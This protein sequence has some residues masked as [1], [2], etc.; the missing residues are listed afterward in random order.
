VT[1]PRI[2]LAAV[3]VALVCLVG[4]AAAEVSQQGS[5]IT[6]FDGKLAP[7]T[8]PR[9][10]PAP[11]AITVAGDVRSS[12]RNGQIPQLQDISVA[13]NRAGHLYDRGLPICHVTSIQPAT[14][15]NAREV[16]GAAIVGHGSVTVETH[17]PT[18]PPF[19]VDAT[20]L[21]FNG[22]V[23]HGQKEIL[24]Q[25]YAQEP[26][27]AFVLTFKLNRRPGMFGTVMSTKLPPE[28]RGWAYLTSFEMTLH[29]VYRYAGAMRSFVSAACSAPA[30]FPGAVFPFAKAT[31]GFDN[32]QQVRTTI[33]RNC[34]VRGG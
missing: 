10:E 18:Q 26:P 8:L 21:A 9:S 1:R 20:L 12:K 14:E 34:H 32:S 5:L 16:C 25:V 19:Q 29:R 33:V 7:N 23:V 17:V 28:A 4:P 24:A 13:I 15:S 11:V 27:G 22:P 3:G 6:T 2:L 31:Y 30:G